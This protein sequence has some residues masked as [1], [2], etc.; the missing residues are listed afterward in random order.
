MERLQKVQGIRK[1][2][3]VWFGIIMGIVVPFVGYA[4]LLMI[5]ESIGAAGWQ[6][7]GNTFGGFSHKLMALIAI[8]MNLIPF[9]VFQ[10]KKMDNAMRGVFMPTMAYIIVWIYFYSAEF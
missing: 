3:A 8:C 9:T 5:N 7:N 1:Y 10:K 6:V 2:N 4:V